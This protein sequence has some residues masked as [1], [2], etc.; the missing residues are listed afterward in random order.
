MLM[1]AL[2]HSDH[3]VLVRPSYYVGHQGFLR[4]KGVS[5]IQ[6]LRVRQIKIFWAHI[7]IGII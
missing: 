1:A 5:V 7:M 3:L 2:L 6:K 4:W